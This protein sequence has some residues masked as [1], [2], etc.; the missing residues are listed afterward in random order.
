MLDPSS[1]GIGLSYVNAT[2]SATRAKRAKREDPTVPWFPAQRDEAAD[3]YTRR[4]TAIPP[5]RLEIMTFVGIVDDRSVAELKN[6]WVMKQ[7]V[8]QKVADRIA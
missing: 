7:A 2:V 8:L 4:S 6:M 1:V 3:M 5:R